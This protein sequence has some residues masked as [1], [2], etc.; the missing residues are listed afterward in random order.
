M[1]ISVQIYSLRNAGDLNT[2]LT[3]AKQAGFEWI[4]SVATHGLTPAQFAKALLDHGLKLSS[5]HASLELLETQPGHVVEA[6][7]LRSQCRIP[8]GEPKS[9]CSLQ[10]A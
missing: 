10:R 1:K 5:M 6:C 8:T 9:G 7:T 4:E 3:L 2:Q